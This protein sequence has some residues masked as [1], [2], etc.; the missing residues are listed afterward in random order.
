[1]KNIYLKVAVCIIAV[2]AITLFLLNSYCNVF[3]NR[4]KAVYLTSS[5]SS[6]IIDK[7][8]C[9]DK[10]LF[11]VNSFDELKSK[12]D[13]ITYKFGIIIDKSIL[14]E[15]S[16]LKDLNKWLLGKKGYPIFVIGYG[17]PV[18]VYFFKLEFATGINKPNI[19]KE[20]IDEFKDQSGFSLAYICSDGKILGTGHKNIDINNLFDILSV[21]LKGD[22]Y[23]EEVCEKGNQ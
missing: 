15:N 1:M 2:C 18:Y 9:K 8:I 3:N 7:E 20:K 13:S 5:K 11:I 14:I 23:A 22:Q 10:K 6:Q 17:K 16:D 19:S 12:A 21:C 4:Y